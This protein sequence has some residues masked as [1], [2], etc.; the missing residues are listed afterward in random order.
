MGIENAYLQSLTEQ[1]AWRSPLF[2]QQL[3]TLGAATTLRIRLR[4]TNRF[5]STV[6][7]ARTTFGIS[8]TGLLVADIEIPVALI[9]SRRDVEFIAHELEHVIEQVQGVDLAA[10]AEQRGSGVYRIDMPG[11]PYETKRAKAAGQAVDREFRET[12][13][14]FRPCETVEADAGS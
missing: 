10:L 7:L 8:K 3:L 5:T 13:E 9:F 6:A 12:E 1:I 14:T 11:R 2:R 4:N